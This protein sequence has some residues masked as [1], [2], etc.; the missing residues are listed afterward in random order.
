MVIPGR[1][2]T[3][4]NGYRYG[5]NGKENDNEVKGVG[6]QQDY[7]MRIYDPRLARFLSLDP[8]QK[9][10]PELTPYQFASNSP[11]QAI[12]LDGLEQ[13][14]F[15][16]SQDAQGKTVLIPMNDGKPQDFEEDTFSPGWGGGVFG[17]FHTYKTTKNPRVEYVVHNQDSKQYFTEPGSLDR[18]TF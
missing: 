10:Y 11:I 18:E 1:K 7:G 2:F 13:Y 9:S 17:I 12:D 3:G 6:N 15:T 14:H 8:L 5:F 16:F 4:G